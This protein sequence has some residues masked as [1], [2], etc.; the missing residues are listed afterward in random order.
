M[1]SRDL[2]VLAVATI[3]ENHD[4]LTTIIAA[5]AAI[6]GGYLV[7]R[8]QIYVADKKGGPQKNQQ[9]IAVDVMVRSYDQALAQKDGVITEQAAEILRLNGELDFYRKKG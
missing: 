6:I 1:L 3:Q 8:G 7:Y 4:V 2:I 5:L 9:E